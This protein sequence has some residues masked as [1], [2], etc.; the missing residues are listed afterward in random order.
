MIEVIDKEG[1]NH[2]ID[3]GL[4]MTADEVENTSTKY[5]SELKNF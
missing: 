2:I 3:Q 1:K 4:G 5:F